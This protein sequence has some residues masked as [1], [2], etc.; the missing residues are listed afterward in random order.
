MSHINFG[1]DRLSYVDKYVINV[2]HYPFLD[3][4]DWVLGRVVEWKISG[5]IGKFPDQF[6]RSTTEWKN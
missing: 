2:Q 5:K 3:R 1:E 4:I 6:F